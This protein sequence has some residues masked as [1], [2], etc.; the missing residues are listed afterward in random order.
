MGFPHFRC[1][2]WPPSPTSFLFFVR[3]LWRCGTDVP[4]RI[5]YVYSP[6]WATA[7]LVLTTATADNSG[8]SRRSARRTDTGNQSDDNNYDVVKPRSGG[9][10]ATRQRLMFCQPLL[11]LLVV[12]RNP[13][14][15]PR[16]N[17]AHLLIMVRDVAVVSRKLALEVVKLQHNHRCR[18]D[19]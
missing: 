13:V 2:G 17:P 6:V 4:R 19:A 9:Q 7:P 10:S 15:S 12:G 11:Y 3:F 14:L 8:A 1:R 5:L 16:D 18:V